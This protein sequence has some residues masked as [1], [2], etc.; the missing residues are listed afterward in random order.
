VTIEHRVHGA[1]RGRVH[2]RIKP[3]QSFPDLWGSPVRPVLL[4]A[5]DQ[6]LNLGG[7]LVGMAVG[8]ARAIGEPFRVGRSPCYPRS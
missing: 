7:Q 8:P 1:D 4:Q 2:I 6:R 5:Y 3:S